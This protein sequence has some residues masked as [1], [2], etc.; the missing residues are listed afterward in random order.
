MSDN[1]DPQTPPAPAT[2][3]PPQEKPAEKTYTQA[4]HEAAIAAAVQ[5]RFKNIPDADELKTLREKAAKA[6]EL[7]Q[8]NLTEL[9][10]AEARAK[11]AEAK[12]AEAEA[13]AQSVQLNNLRLKLGTAKGLPQPLIDR[14]V[15]A[16]ED[17]INEEIEA[18]LPFVKTAGDDGDDGDIG[19]GSNPAG[20]AGGSGKTAEEKFAQSLANQIGSKKRG[21]FG[22]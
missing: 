1:Q 15:G 18:L 4:E 19:D 16:D 14:L 12:A 21:I 10:K 2:G 13:K 20:A 7:E 17:S 3:E 5:K 22:G 9:E 11:A 8:A 6:D